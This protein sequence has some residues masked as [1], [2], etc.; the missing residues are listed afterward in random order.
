MSPK[1]LNAQN[2][3]HRLLLKKLKDK[4][5][6]QI[7]KRFEKNFK[8]NQN[9]IV[10]V[11]GGADSLALSFLTKVY[12]IKNSLTVKYYIVDHKLRHN[13]TLETNLVKDLLKKNFINTDILNWNGEKPVSNIQ[14]TARKKRYKLLINKAKKLKINN[15]LTAH[16]IDDLYENFFIRILRGSGLR[17]LA[18]FDKNTYYD[19]INF[20]RPLI[21]FEKEDLV[22]ITKKVFM[23]YIK[24]PSNDDDKFTRVRIRKLL[25]NLQSEGLNKKKFF[26]TIKN[27]KFSNE[28]I[29][30]YTEKNL[31]DNSSFLKRK[32][33]TILKKEF[34]NQPEEVLF[35]SLME[36]IKSVG[37]K[38]YNVRGKKLD[39]IIKLIISNKKSDF[40]L[41]IGNCI[42]KKVNNSII[43]S[44]EQQIR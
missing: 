11:S 39:N 9:F 13:S 28:T 17:G 38:Y 22:Y 15:I 4:R 10:A 33:S 12:S 7:Y 5:I 23:Y 16:H 42:V 14:S 41:S 6:S 30:F 40:K 18:S 25:K 31:K 32:N 2:K 34:F 8:I 1:N 19:K 35:R 29:K 24:D 44:K 43:V 3:T 20:L 36:I 26:L 21:E 27:L 37:K